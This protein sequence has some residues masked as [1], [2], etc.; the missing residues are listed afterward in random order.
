MEARRL[1]AVHG[2]RLGEHLRGDTPPPVERAAALALARGRA[3]GIAQMEQ[4]SEVMAAMEA[5]GIRVLPMKGPWL[6]DAAHGD[7][8]MRLSDDLDLLVAPSDLA[9]GA[10]VLDSLGYS[11][12]ADRIRA[13]GLPELHLAFHH[14]EH[15]SIDLHWRVHWYEYEF[16][17]D[18]LRGAQRGRDG[19]LRLEGADLAAALLAFYARDGFYGLRLPTDIV[20]WAARSAPANGTG[21]LLD[22]HVARYPPL[23][24]TWRAAALALAR[25]AGVP[26]GTWV[27]D[28]IDTS[29]RRERVAARLANPNGVGSTGQQWANIILVDALLAPPGTAREFL[30]RLLG[31]APDGRRLRHVYAVTARASIALWRV[32]RHQWDPLLDRAG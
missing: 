16:S 19:V 20:G 32:R 21:G 1:T 28:A 10:R 12:A 7:I 18:I 5:A 11:R 6:S 2:L 8:G 29:T 4:A 13:D 25:V 26:P 24:A 27:S 22:G 31:M 9:R 3:F 15:A 23:A 30:G 17:R 14:P